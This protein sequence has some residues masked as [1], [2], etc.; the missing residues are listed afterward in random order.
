MILVKTWAERLDMAGDQKVFN[1]TFYYHIGYGVG[2]PIR[3][4]YRALTVRHKHSINSH[5]EI[6][7]EIANYIAD[8][9]EAH[10]KCYIHKQT[11][12]VVCIPD[13]SLFDGDLDPALWKEELAKIK[14]DKRNYIEIR[15]MDSKDAFK[16]IEEFVNS[17]P[18]SFVKRRLLEA[19]DGPKP[20]ARFKHQI[21][22]CGLERESWF[23][24]RREKNI[25]WVQEQLMN[26]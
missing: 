23:T 12:E 5:M 10:E 14:S 16:V 18:N 24:F 26:N 13:D 21:E 7:R 1:K 25:Q 3:E 6:S 11:L 22:N 2:I 20:F 17:L 19:I 15:K 9:M 8:S 4:L